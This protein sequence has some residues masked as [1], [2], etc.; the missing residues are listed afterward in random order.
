MLH[1][2][3][4]RKK[5]AVALRRSGFTYPEISKRLGGIPKSTLSYWLGDLPLSLQ[6]NSLIQ[7]KKN[8]ALSLLQKK[9]VAANHK[10]RAVYLE[11]LENQN[12]ELVSLIRDINVA[13]IALAMLYLGEGGKNRDAVCFGNSDP[14]IISIFLGLLRATYPIEE[15]KF[16][17]TVQCRADQDIQM[18]EKF[19]SGI[20]QI[21]KAQFYKAQIDARTKGRPTKKQNYKGV[22]RIDYFSAHVFNELTVIAKL[23]SRAVSSVG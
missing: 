11:E 19:W 4:E 8:N 13:K 9:G 5:K 15:K 23:I 10:K 18:L 12:R 6:A 16:R 7:E 14:K 3:D 20:T 22:C 2:S 17:L 21:P 1:M